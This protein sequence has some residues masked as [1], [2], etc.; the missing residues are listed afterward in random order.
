[1]GRTRV[2]GGNGEKRGRRRRLPSRR[3]KGGHDGEK[4]VEWSFQRLLEYRH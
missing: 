1:M 4:Y 3:G 2:G